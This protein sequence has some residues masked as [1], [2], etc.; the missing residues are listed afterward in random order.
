[1]KINHLQKAL[2]W[3]II[4]IILCYLGYLMEKSN[5][6]SGAL[7]DDSY[8]LEKALTRKMIQ[9][10]QVFF[11]T[12]GVISLYHVIRHFRIFEK[13]KSN[14]NEHN[15]ERRKKESSPFYSMS[16]SELDKR[17]YAELKSGHYSVSLGFL[18]ELIDVRGRTLFRFYN[19]RAEC[20]LKLNDKQSAMI[21]AL[22]SVELEAD[23]D[24]NAKGYEIRNK[25]LKQGS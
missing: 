10:V 19:M 11:G 1:M 15:D 21:D 3:V 20:Y 8:F 25:L 22:K 9:F 5:I 23:I 4:G 14:I 6:T 13:V 2:I 7:K 17:A 12:F 24:K 18:N 16:L